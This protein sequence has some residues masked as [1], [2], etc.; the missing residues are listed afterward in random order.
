MKACTKCGEFQP[1][2]CFSIRVASPDGLSFKCR[3]CAKEY[4][5]SRKAHYAILRKASYEKNKDAERSAALSYYRSNRDQ[6]IVRHRAYMEANADKQ[7]QWR[8]ENRHIG[9]ANVAKYR[10]ALK[11]RI[12]RWLSDSER[13][14]IKELYDRCALLRAETGE[15]YHVD[16]IYPLQGKLVSGLHVLANLQILTESEN[17]SK[18]NSYDPT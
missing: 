9:R 15:M 13:A 3:K 1:F 14:A 5:E 4:R 12:P 2:D 18:G 11:Q 7:R 8:E 6:Q 17:A 16:H 10:S